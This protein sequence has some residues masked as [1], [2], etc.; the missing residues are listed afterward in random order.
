VPAAG[1]V[2]SPA[3]HAEP[4]HG[5]VLGGLGL[6]ALVL[7][8][9]TAWRVLARTNTGVN[10]GAVAVAAAIRDRARFG[11]VLRRLLRP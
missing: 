10:T 4:G 2:G 6:I 11:P 1:R 9:G 5:L 3:R 7:F 8:G